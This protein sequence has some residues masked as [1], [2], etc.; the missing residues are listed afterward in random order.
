[1]SIRT[2]LLVSCLLIALMA[3]AGYW[4]WMQIPPHTEIAVHWGINGGPNGFANKT[5]ALFLL[6]IM[7]VLLTAVLAVAPSIEPRRANLIA[8]K[9]L[10]RAGWLGGLLVMVVAQAAIIMTALHRPFD[11]RSTVVAATSLLFI[12]AGNYL[13]KTR[14][15]FFAGIR[16]PWTL[17]SDYSWEKTHRLGG[18]LFVATGVATLLVLAADGTMPAL[19][20]QLGALAASL[21]ATVAMSYVYW[22]RDP[23]KN[24][25]PAMAE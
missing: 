18:R 12:F 8:S 16:T 9:K 19:F 1:M 7:A 2:P 11:V 21:V 20:V 5:R 25:A 10:Y 17:S 14:A 6:P 15:N 22:K 3:A 24:G 23:N 4:A 13:G